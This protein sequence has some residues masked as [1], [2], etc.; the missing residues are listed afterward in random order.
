MLIKPSWVYCVPAV[1][2]GGTDWL[3]DRICWMRLLVLPA[4]C[5][6]HGLRQDWRS[7]G[8]PRLM[9][10][11]AWCMPAVGGNTWSCA[12][13]VDSI[14]V[15][16]SHGGRSSRCRGWEGG[17][18]CS[19]A[20]HHSVCIMLIDLVAMSFLQASKFSLPFR[21]SHLLKDSRRDKI[22]VLFA[23][24]TKKDFGAGRS[25]RRRGRQRFLLS[26]ALT[27]AAWAQ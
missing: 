15:G 5:C 11:K 21:L 7:P 18:G 8:I 16:H 17:S 13:R 27:L 12:S 9:G 23:I 19:I 24:P 3:L 20:R 10:N 1:A 14:R 22:G 4:D 2:A 25:S 6:P 26:L